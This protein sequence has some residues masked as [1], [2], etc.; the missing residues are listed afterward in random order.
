MEVKE[1]QLDMYGQIAGLYNSKEYIAITAYYDQKNIFEI[2]KVARDEN[3]HSNFLAWLL[4]P[5]ES[6]GYG[7]FPL[8]QF[9]RLIALAAKTYPCN[10]KISIDSQ[11]LDKLLIGTKTVASAIVKR[12]NPTP[13]K[14]RMDLLLE[15][16]FE[17]DSKTLPIIIENKVKTNEHDDQ[18]IQYYVFAEEKYKSK[19]YENPLYV[20]LAPKNDFASALPVKEENICKS[21]NCKKGVCERG[22]CRNMICKHDS[23]ILISYQ[24][25]MEHV[26]EP[27]KEQDGSEYA[28]SLVKNYMRCLS[29]SK[30]GDVMATENEIKNLLV[31]FWDKNEKLLSKVLDAKIKD[32]N[33]DEDVRQNMIKFNDSI[34]S[35]DHTKYNFN[36][37]RYVKRRLV[38]AVV[39]QYVDDH[40]NTTF[41]ELLEKF[42]KKLQGSLGVFKEISQIQD[43][44]RY[45]CKDNEI[46]TLNDNT[47]IAVCNQW[48]KPII[49]FINHVKKEL[50]YTITEVE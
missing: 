31:D 18:T 25:I 1:E 23:Y 12:E 32:P 43:D 22:I 36:N 8:Q 16:R 35:R 45:F 33:T 44:T 37:N 21:R 15:V 13:N 5:L 26:L 24:D 17:D 28:K 20:F 4:T 11:L 50:N 48:G 30:K 3:V 6:H 40:P 41:D 19:Q 2:L 47:R 38:L 7:I 14:K 10:N 49:G 39:K 46:I 42:P 27:C 29:D 34:R 9:L